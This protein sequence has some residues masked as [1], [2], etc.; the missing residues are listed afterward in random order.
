[1]FSMYVYIYIFTLMYSNI[2]IYINNI[3]IINIIVMKIV[4]V[5]TR[6]QITDYLLLYV[7][8][9]RQSVGH[10]GFLSTS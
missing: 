4:G 9:Y 1:M 2:Y 6:A 5:A 10:Y 3:S 7:L 8:T